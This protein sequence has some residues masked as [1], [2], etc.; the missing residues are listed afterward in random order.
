MIGLD[1]LRPVK[2]SRHKPKRV[3]RGRGSGSGKT[4]GRGH[5][6]QK[7]R[8]GGS[9][10][11]RAFEGGQ[12][13]LSRRVPKRGFTSIFRVEYNLVNVKDLNRFSAG[14]TVGE[15]ELR[16]LGMAKRKRL[17]IK[18]LGQGTLD[19]PLVVRAHRF[20]ASAREKIEA[21]GGKVE[22]IQG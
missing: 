11:H 1:G 20:S 19:R 22:V 17:P 16:G 15:E 9:K 6:G 4:C 18:V 12:M 5:K 2:G 13:P 21:S 7:A 8:S 10:T 3:G 14:S